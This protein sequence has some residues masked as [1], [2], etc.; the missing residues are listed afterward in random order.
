MRRDHL[1]ALIGLG[2]TALL[3]SML[4]MSSYNRINIQLDRFTND[5][6]PVSDFTYQYIKDS[7]IACQNALFSKINV[8]S[9]DERM[10][11]RNQPSTTV[12]TVTESPKTY[13]STW[14]FQ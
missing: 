8:M 3:V 5:K 9:P 14:S 10:L 13:A 4:A 1:N 11:A 6:I 7:N 2:C 12:G